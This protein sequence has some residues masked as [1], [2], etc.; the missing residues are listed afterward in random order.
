MRDLNK[1]ARSHQLNF[2]SFP[3][4]IVEGSG[5]RPCLSTFRKGRHQPSFLLLALLNWALD[6]W[7]G[8][9]DLGSSNAETL[10]RSSESCGN[11]ST[12]DGKSTKEANGTQRAGKR[13]KVGRR[14]NATSGPK[15]QTHGTPFFP[16]GK[17]QR[18]WPLRA[19]LHNLNTRVT[20]GD[21]R[22]RQK[23]DCAT[24]RNRRRGK[25]MTTWGT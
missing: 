5:H 17:S 6:P 7:K 24:F 1:K 13:G 12:W 20:R 15:A 21:D 9:T 8:Q 16:G 11:R 14:P 4:G 10:G 3:T 18:T 25:D 19:H 22:T 23:R 2:T